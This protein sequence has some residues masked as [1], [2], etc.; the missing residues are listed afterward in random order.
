MTIREFIARLLGQLRP[1]RPHPESHAAA[2][3]MSRHVE[4]LMR[5]KGVMSVGLGSTPDGEPAI[6]VG[7]D[8][9]RADSAADIPTT[10]DG[11]PVVLQQIGRPDA[12][13]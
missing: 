11:V 7:L 8:D 1:D 5:M 2:E 13:G 12:F 6:V 9:P 3:A 4:R 10:V